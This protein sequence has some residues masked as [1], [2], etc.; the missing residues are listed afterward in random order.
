M[1]IL[2]VFDMRQNYIFLEKVSSKTELLD[3]AE[4]LNIY[5]EDAEL[6]DI[7]R[8]KWKTELRLNVTTSVSGNAEFTAAGSNKGYG[9]KI[10]QQQLG[11]SKQ[12]CIAIGDDENDLE[13]FDQVHMAVAMGNAKEN[14]KSAANEITLNC[15]EDGATVFLEQYCQLK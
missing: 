13:M 7:V 11:I 1:G 2:S 12:Q 3:A 14:V 6:S 8:A 15:D 9:I 5:F 10:L 4:K